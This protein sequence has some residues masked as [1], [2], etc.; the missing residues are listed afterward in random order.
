MIEQKVLIT[1]D[2][3]IIN[4]MISTGWIVKSVIAQHVSVG[5]GT[6]STTEIGEFCFIMEKSQVTHAY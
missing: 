5:G 4:G 1:K 3:E 6:Y 2:Q